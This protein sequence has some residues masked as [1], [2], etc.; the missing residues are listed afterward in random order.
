MKNEL[1]HVCSTLPKMGAPRSFHKMQAIDGKLYVTG[2]INGG[3]L[4]R[5]EAFF[6]VGTLKSGEVL[7][8]ATMQWS[9]LPEMA[10]R[11]DSHGMAAVDGKLYVIGG[12]DNHNV[13]N[14]LES[15]EVLDLA[16]MQWSVLPKMAS[17]RSGL[18]MA[19]IDG[20]LYVTG[21]R[22]GMHRVLNCGEVLDLATMQWSAL[23]KMASRRCGHG[24]AAV[25]GKLYVT[26][27]GDGCKALNSGEVLDLATMQWSALPKMASQRSRH[28]MA[29]VDGKLCV[30]GGVLN[31][32][33]LCTSGEVLD[34]ATMQWT[35]MFSWIRVCAHE[36]AAVHGQLYVTG[37]VT[38]C[39]V[40]KSGQVVT[41]RTS[42]WLSAHNVINGALKRKKTIFVAEQTAKCCA[43]R[44]AIAALE[45]KLK[46]QVQSL[47]EARRQLKSQVR[48]LT[49][50]RRQLKTVQDGT[51]FAARIAQPISTRIAGT[52]LEELSVDD[53][54]ELLFLIRVFVPKTVLEQQGI[55][56]VVM[57]GLTEREMDKVLGIAKLGDRRRLSMTL[58]RLGNQQGF[59][60]EIDPT[61]PGALGWDVEKVCEWL[62]SQGFGKHSKCFRDQGIDGPV[63]LELTRDDFE[64]LGLTTGMSTI[65][66]KARLMQKLDV[67]KKR[68]YT[69][70]V[71]GEAAAAPPEKRARHR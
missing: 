29:A 51:E 61:A 69:S 62:E 2:G 60:P 4:E 43:T 52:R 23:P 59:A 30:T 42:F 33:E 9:A 40:L 25:D 64:Q 14:A 17:R 39:N 66:A 41:L 34:L 16:T 8:L 56:G 63:L 35:R 5:E 46:S 19:A 3:I 7:D 54:H 48:S 21:G 31:G 20:K 36:M 55:S 12:G 32:Q 68:T 38:G 44:Q 13:L 10:A 18:G 67:I 11:R 27:G 50:A 6:N 26:G 58:Q 15:G 28:G 45:A 70:Q 22:D 65:A 71:V 37:G 57:I 53:V 24:M 1:F 49:E 47:T